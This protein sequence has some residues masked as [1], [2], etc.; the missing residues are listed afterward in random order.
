MDQGPHPGG[1]RYVRSHLGHSHC[2]YDS[3]FFLSCC[4]TCSPKTPSS[5]SASVPP[6]LG[7]QAASFLC[8]LLL[9]RSKEDRRARA[10]LRNCRWS[11]RPHRAK[12]FH[13]CGYVP[14]PYLGR[15]HASHHWLRRDGP[16]G[17]TGVGPRQWNSSKAKPG[18]S[19][20]GRRS[21]RVGTMPAGEPVWRL[22]LIQ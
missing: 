1:R 7:E 3:C 12:S 19:E 18:V 11:R 9:R 14:R 5:P 22:R 17:T 4:E 10:T 2:M 15:C 20:A 16:G 13:F 8:R 6:L 21:P